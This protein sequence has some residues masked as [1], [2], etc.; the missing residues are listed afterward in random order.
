[1]IRT[2]LTTDTQTISFNVPMDYIGKELEVIVFAK[3][4]GLN[5]EIPTQKKVSFSAISID[6]LGFKFNRDEANER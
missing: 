3:N 1:M 5:K 6:T 4:E 2:T